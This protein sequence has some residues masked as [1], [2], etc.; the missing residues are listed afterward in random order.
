MIIAIF[1]MH[2]RC[3]LALV[4][5]IISAVSGLSALYTFLAILGYTIFLLAAI[6]PLLAWVVQ[7]TVLNR[8]SAFVTQAFVTFI[9]VFIFLSAWFTEI[10]GVHA[11]FGAF[12]VGLIMPRGTG[13]VEG[14]A[15]KIE[16]VVSIVFLPLV[17]CIL[18]S[19]P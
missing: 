7:R 3:L 9:F 15:E 8:K 16:D 2:C 12:L 19:L 13:I 11:I 6:R 5:S 17:S 10:I 4:I 18:C 14:L 1:A